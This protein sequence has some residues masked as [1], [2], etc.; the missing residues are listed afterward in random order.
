MNEAVLDASALLALLN[1]EPGADQVAHYIPGAVINAVNL[2]EV[3]GKLA[4]SGMPEEEIH[5]VVGLTGLQVV[6]FDA[7]L[8]H[9][10]G[11]LRPVTR[12]IGLSLGDHACL[13]TGMLM[14]L[15]VI[16]S[17]RIWRDCDL[18]VT[19]VLIR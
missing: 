10:A 19:V 6:P 11:R 15:P 17:D 7:N 2:S 5:E 12:K 13:A 3:I 14:S 4:E 16:T 8:A 18:P 1:D 9:K